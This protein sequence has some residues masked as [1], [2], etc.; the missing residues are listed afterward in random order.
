MSVRAR[1]LPPYT[2]RVDD[3]RHR[4]SRI[5]GITALLLL[6]ML[7]GFL[8]T[9]LPPPLFFV[10]ALPL[11]V[12]AGL[13]LWM[14]PDIEPALDRR[15][16]VLFMTFLVIAFVWPTYI[17]FV[18]PGV[19]WA[20]FQRM[21]M[22]LL[23]L[24]SVYQIATSS[25]MRDEIVRVISA[26]KPMYWMFLLFVLLQF[27]LA[28]AT[29]NLNS[30]YFY[31]LIF[32]YYLFV[33]AAWLFAHEG[34]PTKFRNIFMIGMG[35]QGIYS[36]LEYHNKAPIWANHIP[37]FM[38][39]DPELLDKVLGYSGRLGVGDYRVGSIYLTA[40]TYAEM[41]SMA[42]PFALHGTVEGKTPLRRWASFALVAL[43]LTCVVFNDQRSS[44]IGAI[45]GFTAYI[46]LW[47]FR[48]LRSE[49]AKRDLVGTA[50]F[51][52]FP[53]AIAMVAAAVLFVPRLHV[54]VLGG[55]QHQFSDAARDTQWALAIDRMLQNPL[56]YGPF[57]APST[58]G[59]TNMKGDFALDS[60]VITVMIESGV[61]GL[62]LYA[63]MLLSA[64]YL[65]VRTYFFSETVEEKLAGPL[66]VSLTSF[67]VIKT[68]LS[69]T[70]NHAIAFTLVALSVALYWRQQQRLAGKPALAFLTK[71]TR[72]QRIR[73]AQAGGVA[74][75]A[76]AGALPAR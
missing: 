32:W 71:P 59:Y 42:L 13:A 73:A 28:V 30:R 52:S 75:G 8:L 29:N 40:L 22:A 41:M 18:L 1:I 44:V 51:W 70:E 10:P 4:L 65:A 34:V 37:P 72:R 24:T 69:Q 20:S 17:A 12:L 14:A 45:I 46:G 31:S 67:M 15:I 6:A 36:V 54:M 26:F 50:V 49:A 61:I 21:A 74:T 62:L 68:V 23:L 57:S 2:R 47:A 35:V 56:G 64:W 58:V 11:I 48:R 76:P 33:L 66:A 55:S 9:L 3:L 27:V 60:Y 16:E 53:A 38:Q 7:M 19:G 39:V 25:R 43:L 5:V 63:G